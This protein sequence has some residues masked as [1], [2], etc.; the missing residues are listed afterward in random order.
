MH[1]SI[2]VLEES[3][4]V[5]DLFESALPKEYWDWRIEHESFPENYVSKVEDML[6]GIIFLSNQDQKNDYATVKE[7]RTSAKSKHIPI[8]LLTIAKDKLDEK[9]L[10]S[11]G[12]QGFLRK[13]FE[14]ATLLEQIEATLQNQ[15]LQQDPRD[16]LENVDVVDEEL[17]GLLS[18]GPSS[19]ITIDNLEGELDPTLQL[20]PIEAESMLQDDED[21]QLDAIEE[22][23]DLI[24]ADEEDEED[25]E[26]P[27][28]EMTDLA[29]EDAPEE[30]E[31]AYD[32]DDDELDEIEQDR[33]E[34]AAIE[35]E[36]EEI[37]LDFDEYS[38]DTT[39]PTSVEDQS[40]MKIA[41][42]I[43][44][45]D[46]PKAS[47]KNE[48]KT[49][50]IGLMEIGVV[51]FETEDTLTHQSES[52]F[53]TFQVDK[54]L[55]TPASEETDSLTELTVIQASPDL[56]TQ[57]RNDSIVENT[58]DLA[59]SSTPFMELEVSHYQADDIIE[60]EHTEIKDEVDD[61]FNT[62]H[63]KEFDESTLL[64]IS[65]EGI[66]TEED[67]DEMPTD[68]VEDFETDEDSLSESTDFGADEDILVEDLDEE[69]DEGTL[70]IDEQEESEVEL[71]V[72]TEDD[73]SD[74]V[75][76]NVED[77]ESENFEDDEEIQVV[78]GIEDLGQFEQDQSESEMPFIEQD[79][80]NNFEID[81]EED[82]ELSSEEIT[83]DEV[84]FQLD[85]MENLDSDGAQMSIQEMINFRQVMKAKYDIPE[86][87]TTDSDEEEAEEDDLEIGIMSDD[88]IDDFDLADPIEDTDQSPASE[89]EM[90]MILEDETPEE[91]MD[92][93]LE[94]DAPEEEMDMIMEDDAPEEEMDMIME[95]DAPEEEMD[96]ILEDAPEEEM[97]MI[98]EE[99]AP[100]EE[101]D[102]ILEDDAPEEEM[103]MIMEDDAPEEEMEMIMEDDAPEEEMDMILE[104]DETQADIADVDIFAETDDEESEEVDLFADS[105]DGE[106]SEV[107]MF[108]DS[109]DE[110]SEE[111]DLFADS[112]DA[113]ESEVDMFVDSEDEDTEET[114]LLL[115]DEP[116]EGDHL[117]ASAEDLFLDGD[118]TD[119]DDGDVLTN[120]ETL[121][122]D[123]DFEEID[124]D[125]FSDSSEMQEGDDLLIDTPETGEEEAATDDTPADPP[126]DSDEID[127]LADDLQIAD[128]F[129]ETAESEE[130]KS[131]DLPDSESDTELS[132]DD[133]TEEEPPF[134]DADSELLA[135]PEMDDSDDIFS[136]NDVEDDDVF[137]EVDLME[138]TGD[139]SESEVPFD[140]DSMTDQNM[141][142]LEMIS[143]ADDV[144][145]EVPQDVFEI[146]DLK[147]TDIAKDLDK[148]TEP[149]EGESPLEESELSED[150]DLPSMDEDLPD[151]P[152]ITGDVEGESDML[153][154][155]DDLA[156]SDESTEQTESLE[157]PPD[158]I[159]VLQS[160]DDF[161]PFAEESETIEFSGET[162]NAQET[163]T[164]DA[165]SPEAK[166]KSPLLSPDARDKLSGMIENVI[167]DTIQ[168]T[169]HEMLPDMMDKIIQEEL[170]D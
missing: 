122:D 32:A 87:S 53:K 16:E 97:D 163:K 110:E 124:E 106:E 140:P 79:E 96:M 45:Q 123:T 105:D 129:T 83:D 143:E 92:M 125:P 100:E 152:S 142:D 167:S 29:G 138:E 66:D 137:E 160:E 12:I 19:G 126:T 148:D 91:E 40:S 68:D 52:Q 25:E 116:Q 9:R 85:D 18:G 158:S 13:P 47:L 99:D 166:K 131:D 42:V 44:G 33:A 89:E 34:T 50:E 102:M 55:D 30:I 69:L 159:E 98:L 161:E 78:D 10:R 95:D 70:L 107:D 54:N 4:M 71:G 58:T 113:E 23:T 14:S 76:S 154:D 41:I 112:D 150:I 135:P 15:K 75:I 132:A 168:N 36:L 156:E 133:H 6:P 59:E 84:D 81:F 77:E 146:S 35:I 60:I 139:S 151:F 144:T 37:G 20:H 109:E 130:S 170:D 90:D 103:D 17:M 82:E 128:E 63:E 67:S 38:Q 62:L 86:T 1:K 104:E 155:A 22:M 28:D 115:D 7:L 121:K 119:I 72:I 2:L 64:E 149:D 111:V 65:V 101:M 5:H 73:P 118:E 136:D 108:V 120:D 134:E 153:L 61:D 49:G 141:S 162:A 164:I 93:I 51:P 8:L 127:L 165:S 27:F 74:I 147:M 26:V 39:S 117:A 11:L 114:D 43:N 24:E 3:Q 80:M 157:T 56:S 94:E 88:E 145:I 48:S 169:L 46:G 21:E 57:S 31:I